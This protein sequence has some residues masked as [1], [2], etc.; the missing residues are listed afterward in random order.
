M[1]EAFAGRTVGK[2]AMLW[3]ILAQSI[4]DIDFVA[5]FWSDTIGTLFSHRGFTH[6]ILFAA[7]V[8]PIIAGLA[9][10]WHRPHNISFR[11]W[12][13]FIGAVILMHIFLDAFNNYGVGWFEPFNDTRISFNTMYVADFFFS[14]APA[15][16]CIL[17]IV[18][19]RKNPKRRWIWQLG[20]IIPFLYLAYGVAN[21][22]Y[23]SRETK[24]ILAQQH[25]K[26]RRL[27]I[28]PAPL[29]SWLWFVAADVDSGFYI[30][31]R[32]VFDRKS[33]NDF[34]Y[35]PR[36]SFLEDS[37]K[38]EIAMRKIM[39]FSQDWYTLEKHAD[40]ILITDLRFG[41]VVGWQDPK[42]S[43]AFYY[44]LQPEI[45]NTLVVQRGRFSKWDRQSFRSL[46]R[47][48]K[49]N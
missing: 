8:T 19:N 39:Q 29:L 14:L 46:L 5:A 38:D 43:F 26:P 35:I 15:I 30:G 13:L 48:I 23:I 36:N 20:L 4:P 33:T 6:S 45:D 1:G 12:F 18:L 31:Y 16:A 9:H 24:K 34:H 17:L 28:T 47:R 11:R 22:N 27:L 32:S 25:I 2:K 3:G 49:G 42:E 7:L 44:Y 21:R 10:H 40:T 37:V 41:Q